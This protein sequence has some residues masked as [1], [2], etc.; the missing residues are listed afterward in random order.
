[1]KKGVR[2]LLYVLGFILILL[3]AGFLLPSTFTISRSATIQAQPAKV[4]AVL[5]DLKTYDAWM[6]WNQID[7]AMTKEYGPKT[8]GK[9]AWYS[10]SSDNWK[11]GEGKLEITQ[12]V[13]DQSVTTAL[14][15]AGDDQPAK[16]GWTLNPAETAATTVTW[17]M[18]GN[19]GN[20]PLYRWMTFLSKGMMEEQFDNGLA[21]LKEKIESGVLTVPEAKWTIEE[22]Q[23]P[24]M[25]VIT[26][27]DTAAV[28]GDVGPLLQKAYG[29]LSKLSE[30]AAISMTGAP[31]AWYHTEHEP[32][33]IEAAIPLEKAPKNTSGRIKW[34]T[35]P[36][37]KAV[38]VHFYGP[39]EE[40]MIAYERIQEWL[41]KN[42]KKAKGASYDIYVDDP[43]TKSSM[44][45]VRT[46]IVQPIE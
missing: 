19:N 45:E 22:I 8:K 37:G 5:S 1:M 26:I 35:V 12:A 40:S 3:L 39:Y 36:A 11:V 13:Q 44:Y 2:V 25:Q 21:Q 42:Q 41:Q 38:V 14:Y 4:Y 10:W 24:A 27:L 23:T 18:S 9:G 46:D 30:Q 32:F 34:K 16:G 29:E 17:N 6:P 15:M 43:A 7:T 31:L 33:V 28:M 20:N